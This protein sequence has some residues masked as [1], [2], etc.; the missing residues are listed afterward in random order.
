[1]EWQLFSTQQISVAAG[2]ALLGIGLA[3]LYDIFRIFR[4]ILFSGTISIFIQDILFWSISGCATYIYILA[5]N[6]GEIRFFI[7]AAELLGALIYY[8]TLGRVIYGLTKDIVYAI[9]SFLYK[10]FVFITKPFRKLLKKHETNKK[11]KTKKKKIFVLICAIRKF[12]I[13][14]EH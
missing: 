9:R 14:A 5:I 12:T 3:V 1:M 10:I 11:D 6:L 7:L 13:F 4:L 2:A 8:F